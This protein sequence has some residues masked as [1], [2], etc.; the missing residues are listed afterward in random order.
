VSDARPAVAVLGLGLIGGSLLRRL[1]LDGA[2]AVGFDSDPAT[3]TAAGKAGLAAHSD[4]AA[5]LAGA[6]LVVLAVPLPGIAELVGAVAA[7]DG[8]PILTDV[9]SVKARVARVAHERAPALRYVGGHPMAGTERSGFA[10]A[11][12]TLF[13]AAAWALCLDAGTDPGTDLDAWLTVA[14]LAVDVG[15]RVVP[16]TAAAH[17]RAVAA[18]SHVPH[19]LA[20]A[21]ADA[22]GSDPLAVGLAAGSFR[23]ATRVMQSRPELVAAM[24]DG[25]AE[26]LGPALDHVVRRLG[27]LREAVSA[28]AGLLPAFAAAQ[29]VRRRWDTRFN[30]REIALE[31]SD[32][33]LR[34]RLLDV[35]ATGGW[36]DRIGTSVIRAWLPRG[37]GDGD[38]HGAAVGD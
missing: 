13:D 2:A 32:P 12:P 37:S 1:T 19:L 33:G 16:T 4:L 8:A 24:C 36:V 20:A 14:R 5:A 18:S 6:D 29:E 31:R 17:D 11:D 9:V 15:A 7:G 35:G 21:L 28:G 10:A 34:D 25:N 38:R 22:V 3:V 23:D 27:D 30:A 26:A